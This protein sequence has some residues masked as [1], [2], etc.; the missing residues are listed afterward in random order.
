[1]R[2]RV[3]EGMSEEDGL[4]DFS[5]DPFIEEAWTTT[6]LRCK[7][8]HCKAVNYLNLGDLNDQTAP[9]IEVLVCWSCCK[10]SWVL[11]RDEAECYGYESI[12]DAFDE[13]GSKT[14]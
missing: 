5:N 2:Q 11:D 7:C 9:D 6:T 1:M 12:D 10:K 13:K 4:A 14:L 8:P 3:K